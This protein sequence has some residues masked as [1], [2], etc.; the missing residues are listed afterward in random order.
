MGYSTSYEGE[1]KFRRE[2]TASELSHV[3]KFL[4]ADVRDFND[5]DAYKRYGGYW[6]HIDLDL[7]DD[8]SGLEWSGAEKTGDMSYILN[9]LIDK[10]RE[11]IPDFALTGTMRATGESF[12]D[13]WVLEWEDGKA[14][15]TDMVL[16]G[17]VIECPHCEE[18]FRLE[19][20][21]ASSG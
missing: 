3:K 4:G 2:L 10:V 15:H 1:L 12:D 17:K 5:G 9:Y 14:V 21:G 7:L 18:K 6:Y 8:F 16:T 11:K 13:R 19:P 20:D